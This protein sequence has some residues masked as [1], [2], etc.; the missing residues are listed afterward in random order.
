MAK[1]PIVA[2]LDIG[3]SSIS[4]VIAERGSNNTYRIHGQSEVEYSGFIDEDFLREGELVDAI[5]HA[6][7][8]AQSRANQTV[9]SIYV[10]VPGAF[11]ALYAKEI[12][13]P[14]KSSRI[15]VSEDLEDIFKKGA[16]N[17][18]SDGHTLI[19]SSA[20]HYKL[21]DGRYLDNPVGK[22]SDKL[23][24]K[25]SYCYA[26][27]T[28]VNKIYEILKHFKINKIDFISQNY[29]QG[30]YL[31]TQEERDSS[32]VIFDIGYI[33]TNVM[34]VSGKGLVYLKSFALGGGHITAD[35]QECFNVPFDIAE[36]FK[37]KIVLS[38]CFDENGEYVIEDKGKTYRIK[39]NTLHE[40][41]KFR[42]AEMVSLVQTCLD[43]CKEDFLRTS[44]MYVTGGGILYM[45][46]AKEYL[47]K[48]FD[49]MCMQAGGENP[50]YSEPSKTSAFAVLEMA[51]G[52]AKSKDSF[53]KRMFG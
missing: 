38:F 28:F 26:K 2:V 7:N 10:G 30:L 23:I 27:N 20:I 50:E 25:V 35:I 24:G 19:H 43:N 6:L 14:F 45:R 17:L 15:I 49:V 37:R 32:I 51:L 34:L 12:E 52:K 44:K 40:N 46:G 8:Q 1:S 13:I 3:S 39:A 22:K 18:N 31:T 16:E 53:I 48:Q 42:I 33:T 41:V 47:A 11:V 9:S 29:A 36:Q 21:S 5:G 4:V